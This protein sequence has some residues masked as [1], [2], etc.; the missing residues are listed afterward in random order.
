MS[1]TPPTTTTMAR[2]LLLLLIALESSVEAD[3]IK[4]ATF[5]ASTPCEG[6]P[7][8]VTV[9]P[10]CAPFPLGSAQYEC[11]SATS[12]IFRAFD[13]ADCSGAPKHE[14]EWMQ[15]TFGCD[16]IFNTMVTCESGDY[17]LNSSVA[18]YMYK[19]DQCPPTVDP[20]GINTIPCGVC[21]DYGDGNYQQ[22]ECNSTHY[23]VALHSAEDCTD[24]TGLYQ[25]KKLSGCTETTQ[26]VTNQVCT[27]AA[28]HIS[29]LSTDSTPLSVPLD[30]RQI[31]KLRAG[32]S[33][34]Q[35]AQAH[36]L[37]SIQGL[38]RD[39]WK[40]TDMWGLDNYHSVPEWDFY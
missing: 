8:M 4:L 19:E 34:M 11:T 15:F 40:I 30:A 33:Q 3:Y 2:S 1:W 38:A 13:S 39:Q 9:I 17:D 37:A 32:F 24:Y 6:N 35:N 25:T 5:P 31:A 20:Q 36:G 27:D 29:S 26:S 28:G 23:T 12:A 14:S 18:T 16:A 22:Y 10:G 21:F 7:F